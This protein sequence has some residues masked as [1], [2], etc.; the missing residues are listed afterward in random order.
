MLAGQMADSPAATLPS[1]G[2]AR[3]KGTLLMT[4]WQTV[5]PAQTPLAPLRQARQTV[6]LAL[7]GAALG[8]FSKWLDTQASNTLPPLLEQLDVRNFLGRLAPWLL[9]AAL[10]AA[11]SRSPRWAA[12]NVFAFL[13]AML[14]GYYGYCAA[15]AGFFPKNY[16]MI[17]VG[18]TLASPLLAVPCW[19]ARADGGLAFVLSS[20]VLAVLFWASFSYGW[21]YL[22]PVSPLELVTFAVGAVCFRRRTLA[23]T[24]LQ[25]LA[26]FAA[27]WVLSLLPFSVV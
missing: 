23:A 16:A 22:Q 13:A 17:W 5:R 11:G 1:A 19:Y 12:G 4:F 3:R 2:F 24:L 26:A 27:A 21:L 10:I 15:A 6:C 7:A 9:W 18:L 8:V 25:W 14:A 20:G